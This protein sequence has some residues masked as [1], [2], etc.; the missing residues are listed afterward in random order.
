MTYRLYAATNPSN[1]VGSELFNGW[2]Q[3]S[4]FYLNLYVDTVISVKHILVVREIKDRLR[5]SLYSLVYSAN[6]KKT[7]DAPLN[8]LLYTYREFS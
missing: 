8:A 3:R 1:K 7:V 4:H 2:D 5:A 6:S